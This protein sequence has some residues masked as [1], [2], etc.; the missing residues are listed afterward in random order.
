M[1]KYLSGMFFMALLLGWGIPISAISFHPSPVPYKV[2]IQIPSA[3]LDLS[4][5][6]VRDAQN[7]KINSVAAQSQLESLFVNGLNR[8][9]MFNL[10]P[11][12]Q[13]VRDMMARS[14]NVFSCWLTNVVGRT[15]EKIDAWWKGNKNILKI[16][17]HAVSVL[18]H[19]T[20]DA[21]FLLGPTR[22]S[23]VFLIS[24]IISS[25]VILR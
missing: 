15:I 12:A 16:I 13:F 24:S 6:D 5:L 3:S 19:Q 18:A 22:T 21:S 2:F 20:T 17:F 10:T 7:R 1:K 8:L 25:T 23:F 4:D 9:L 14:W 11:T